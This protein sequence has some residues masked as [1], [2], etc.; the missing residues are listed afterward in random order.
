MSTDF[1]GL[2]KAAEAISKTSSEFRDKVMENVKPVP[3]WPG[4]AVGAAV[5]L[6]LFA[7]LAKV[8][9]P[10]PDRWRNRQCCNQYVNEVRGTTNTKVCVEYRPCTR[11]DV[12]STPAVLLVF[13][14]IA[15]L[16]GLVAGGGVYRLM[17]TL[18]NPALSA[19]QGLLEG[20]RGIRGRRRR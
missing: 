19:A 17:F 8:F 10:K 18:K 7:L 9:Y 4:I 5:G 11:E 13:A 2:G 12:W 20:F 6:L 16:V 3:V 15:A 1:F 14:G